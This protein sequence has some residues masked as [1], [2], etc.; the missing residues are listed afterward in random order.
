[1]REN[2]FSIPSILEEN[3]LSKSDWE[4]SGCNEDTLQGIHSNYSSIHSSLE[5]RANTYVGLIKQDSNVHSLKWRVKSASSLTAKI[6]RKSGES[7]PAY[8]N[9]SVS[10]YRDVVTDLIGV[11]ALHLFKHQGLAILETLRSH[12]ISRED[13]IAYVRTGDPE[14]TR[15]RFKNAGC[16]VQDHKAGYRSIHFSA[17]DNS[18]ITAVGVEIQIRTIFEE[19]WSE[20]DHTIRYP[21]GDSDPLLSRILSI[22]NQTAGIADEMGSFARTLL[23]Q[24]QVLRG[25]LAQLEKEKADRIIELN[26]LIDSL[27]KS[28]A[29]HAEKEKVIARLKTEVSNLITLK[30]VEFLGVQSDQSRFLIGTT[31]SATLQSLQNQI[32]NQIAALQIPSSDLIA[33]NILTAKT[34]TNTGIISIRP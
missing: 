14:D 18:T 28:Q 26:D 9:I 7:D 17:V 34:N 21:S 31:A 4:R 1:M 22:L 32:T 33:S 25:Q 27:Q 19:A 29:A 15:T 23:E 13:V 24:F 12:W 16:N 30:P 10:N 20:I 6:I 2:Q 8:R 11:R 5:A 3:K